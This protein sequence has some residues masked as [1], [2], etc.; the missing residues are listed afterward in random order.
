MPGV[1][2]HKKSKKWTAQ[3]KVNNKKVTLGSFDT[4]L[5]VRPD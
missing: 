1:G 2:W 5:E 3:I 4:P